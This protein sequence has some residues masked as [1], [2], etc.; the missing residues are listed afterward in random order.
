MAT[1]F[2]IVAADLTGN[3]AWAGAPPPSRASRAGWPPAAG[4]LL[5]PLSRR[6]GLSP[7]LA[8]GV[9]GAGAAAASVELDCC[10][11]SGLASW[12]WGRPNRGASAHRRRSHPGAVRGRAISLVVWGGT[13]GAVGAAAGRAEQPAGGRA[14]L[15][16]VDRPIAV[17]C[18]IALSV[19]LSFAGL[20]PEPL[21]LSRRL[22][23]SPWVRHRLGCRRALSNPAAARDPGAVAAVLSQMVMVMLMGIVPCTCA[24]TATP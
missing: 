1:V 14:G 22:S 8:L 12:C 13:I 5:G 7:A 10:G 24:I 9:L 6:L 18:L 2:S 23:G 17:G 3:P 20:R 15:E 21:E 19:A 16:R 11:S 4:R